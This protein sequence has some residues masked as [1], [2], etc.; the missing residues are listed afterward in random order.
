MMSYNIMEQANEKSNFFDISKYTSKL[1]E[2][3]QITRNNIIFC[4]E[5]NTR[6][7]NAIYINSGLDILSFKK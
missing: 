6:R 7:E 2:S 3:K 1:E 4:E 5:M